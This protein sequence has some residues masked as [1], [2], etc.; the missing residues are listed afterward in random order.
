M[1]SGPDYPETLVGQGFQPGPNSKNRDQVWTIGTGLTKF[2]SVETDAP[3]LV[4]SDLAIC[5]DSP[6]VGKPR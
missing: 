1:A 5:G 4:E 3:I 2:D 6:Q